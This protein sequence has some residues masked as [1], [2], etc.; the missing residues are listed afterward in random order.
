MKSVRARGPVSQPILTLGLEPGH[1]LAHGLHADAQ[2]GGNLARGL[3]KLKSTAN[4]FRPTQH[5]QAS[6]LMTVHPVLSW[7]SEAS[8]LQLPRSGPV[9]AGWI[10]YGKLTSRAPPAGISVGSRCDQMT[11]LASDLGDAATRSEACGYFEYLEV[12]K[13]Q[14]A[15]KATEN[16]QFHSTYCVGGAL[17]DGARSPTGWR[18]LGCRCVSGTIV[19]NLIMVSSVT[20]R[21]C[22]CPSHNHSN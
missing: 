1:P 13:S 6:I 4:K 15:Q 10:T 18:R 11:S 12:M 8:Q 20:C 2:R 16:F 9:R 19:R 3:V 5:R 22:R 17:S 14:Q 21:F 7:N